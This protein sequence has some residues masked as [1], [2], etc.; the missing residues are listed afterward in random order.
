MGWCVSSRK[1]AVSQMGFGW[2]KEHRP[3]E[4]AGVGESQE[5]PLAGSLVAEVGV[6]REGLLL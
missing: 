4:I 5:G 1:A 3:Q 6:L 2:L